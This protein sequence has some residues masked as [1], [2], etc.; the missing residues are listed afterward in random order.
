MPS[1][2]GQ[3]LPCPGTSLSSSGGAPA[4]AARD[5]AA[6]RAVGLPRGLR[7]VAESGAGGGA[8]FT[9]RPPPPS[10][11]A[12]YASVTAGRTPGVSDHDL[13]RSEAWL[14]N[15]RHLAD[16]IRAIIAVPLPQAHCRG[17][18]RGEQ[19]ARPRCDTG[20]RSTTTTLMDCGYSVG[21]KYEFVLIDKGIVERVAVTFSG[22]RQ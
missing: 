12:E 1:D 14:G 10:C 6:Y 16:V 20:G 21:P 9:A 11:R 8:G 13:R 5:L 18:G 4:D 3:S 15:R 22:Y 17:R 2:A 7:R 19:L